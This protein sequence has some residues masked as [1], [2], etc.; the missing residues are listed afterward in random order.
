[1]D[2]PS[3]MPEKSSINPAD[4]EKALGGIDYNRYL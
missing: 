2:F 1:M 3:W 4:F